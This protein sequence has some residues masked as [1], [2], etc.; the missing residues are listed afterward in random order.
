[1]FASVRLPSGEN[2]NFSVQIP[3]IDNALFAK[4]DIFANKSR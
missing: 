4:K 3:H 1:M 2:G